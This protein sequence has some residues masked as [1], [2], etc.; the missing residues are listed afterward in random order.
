M[1][2][3]LSMSRR[4]ALGL[5]PASEYTFNDVLEMTLTGNEERQL[6]RMEETLD[7][8]GWGQGNLE[9]PDGTVCLMGAAMD[10]QRVWM[11]T[12]SH[13]AEAAGVTVE[14]LDDWNDTPGRTEAEVRAVIAKARVIAEREAEAE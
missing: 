5:T 10:G 7:R 4:G 14:Q 1:P 6:D 2:N 13:L 9:N 3:E 12:L 11:K 8:R